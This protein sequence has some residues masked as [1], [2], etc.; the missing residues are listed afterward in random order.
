MASIEYLN[1]EDGVPNLIMADVFLADGTEKTVAVNPPDGKVMNVALAS[2][3]LQD[4]ENG[5]GEQNGESGEQD[6]E[7]AKN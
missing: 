2:N 5:D 4:G 6:G 7:N 1:G 3:D